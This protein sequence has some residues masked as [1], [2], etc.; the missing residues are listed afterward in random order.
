MP[1]EMWSAVI[2]DPVALYAAILSTIIAVA[3]VIRTL[4]KWLTSG[5]RAWA[6]ILNPKE[7]RA[8]NWKTAEVIVANISAE[9]FVVREIIVTM[10]KSRRSKAMQQARFYHG[11]PFNPSMEQIPNPNGKPNSV[12][13]VPKIVRPGE[14]LHQHILPFTDYDPATHWLR[15]QAF[16]RQRKAPAIGWAAPISA[17]QQEILEPAG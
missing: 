8:T 5:P 15:V 6:G 12:I 9:P 11:T 1:D 4:V 16:I 14:E 7:V 2:A 3:A 17:P 10:H 13:S